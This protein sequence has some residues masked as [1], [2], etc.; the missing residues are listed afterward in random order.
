MGE[1]MQ[2]PGTPHLGLLWLLFLLAVRALFSDR[3]GWS[4]RVEP[5]IPYE[6]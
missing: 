1:E 6:A 2:Y 4:Q 3:Q 5:H